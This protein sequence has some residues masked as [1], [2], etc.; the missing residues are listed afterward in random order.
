MSVA[1]FLDVD[2]TLTG[3]FI[4]ERFAELLSCVDQYRSIERRFQI[5]ELDAAAFGDELI[6]LFNERGF[7]EAVAREHCRAIPL[8]PWANELLRLPLDRYLVSSGPSYYIEPLAERYGIP[9]THVICSRYHFVEPG[10][11]LGSCDAVDAPQKAMF[12]QAHAPRYLLTIGIGDDETKDGPFLAQCTI[13]I[14][15]TR[16]APGFL[17]MSSFSTLHTILSK[18][19]AS[20]AYSRTRPSVFIGSAHEALGLAQALQANL[21]YDAEPS[22]WTQGLFSPSATTI[23]GLE[24]ALESFDF[25]VLI[26]TPEDLVSTAQTTSPGPRDNVL[27]ELGLFMGRLGRDRCFFVYP[28]GRGL[29]LPSD[30]AGVTALL[31]DADWAERDAQP[32]LGPAA[33]E[34]TNQIQALG[35]RH[36]GL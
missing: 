25:A 26:L 4:Q 30:L 19:G 27:F 14:L 23:E 21:A 16:S 1:L 3:G 22:V 18:L 5:G 28:R 36:A 8:Q 7:T 13:A 11:M 34:I 24:R 32:A 15:T 31:Y 29:H 20:S 10:G 2:N 17:Q 35:F 6:A 9:P 12:V 33:T